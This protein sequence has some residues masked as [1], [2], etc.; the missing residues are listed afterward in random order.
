MNTRGT[1]SAADKSGF[2]LVV[3]TL[4]MV[5]AAALI[6][7]GV[8]LGS[9]HLLV[10]RYHQRTDQLEVVA[11]A[12][13]EKARAQLNGNPS[14]FPE[15]GYVVLEDNAQVSNGAGGFIPG[16]RRSMYAGPMDIATGQSGVFGAVISVATDD[17]GAK[18]VRRIMLRQ[19]SFA[20]FAYFT[21]VEPS[22]ISFGSG[23]QIWGPV[24]SNDFL[25]IYGSGAT[26]HAAT[27]TAKTVVD[28]QYG[29]FDKGY[30]QNVSPIPLPP[31]AELTRLS[32]YAQT[33][34]TR[35][36]GN[37]GDGQATT[38]VE[39]MAIDL[40]ADGDQNDENEGFIRVYQ[41]ADFAWVSGDVDMR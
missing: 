32:N 18:V 26:F 7:G 14:L 11:S 35:I 25:K 24:H 8:T 28:S 10:N 36:V 5:V 9:N 16:V 29:I 21:D 12:G 33:G 40:N 23:D 41:S 27:R 2:A 31:V 39:F 22:N 13:L 1:W 15:S 6:G 17:G 3:V 19:E 34:G 20:R 37:G 38:R 4:V 30:Q